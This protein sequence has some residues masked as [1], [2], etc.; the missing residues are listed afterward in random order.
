[1]YAR[2]LAAQALC[3]FL[4]C[5]LFDLSDY[6]VRALCQRMISLPYASYLPKDSSWRWQLCEERLMNFYQPN[7]FV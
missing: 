3:G 2:S 7:L 6:A 4:P 1:M 5:F